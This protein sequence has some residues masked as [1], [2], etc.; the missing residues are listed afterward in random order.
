LIEVAVTAGLVAALLGLVLAALEPA[1]GL[2]TTQSEV[3]DMQQ[4]LRAAHDAVYDDLVGVGAG[5]S[6]GGV[7]ASV[8]PRSGVAGSWGPLVAALPPVWPMRLGSRDADSPGTARSDRVTLLE[9]PPGAPLAAVDQPVA[10]ADGTIAVRLGPGCAVG[11]PVCGFAQ[12]MD[13]LVHD[14]SGAFDTFTIVSV[15]PP[16]LVVRHTLPDWPKVYPVGSAL[17]QIESRTY[18]AREA[19]GTRPPQLVRYAGGFHP[20]VPV[21]DYIVGL[22]FEYFGESE[23]PRMVKP[24]SDPE[25]PWTTYGPPPPADPATS[26]A[27]PVTNCVFIATGAPLASPRLSSLGPGAGALVPLPLSQLHDGPF[28][29]DDLAPTRYDADLLR[30]R[31]VEVTIRVQ[32]ALD[33]LRGPAGLLF[34]YGGTGQRADRY[35]PDIE[36]RVRVTPRN[37]AL[38]R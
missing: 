6:H 18:Y 31:S 28:C 38:A 29:P 7:V 23:P 1:Q 13:V 25:G 24:L 33:S 22:T 21:V 34:S 20:D 2:F 16:H 9:V 19:R 35:A 14:G 37:L 30:I 8:A 15:A 12:D 11:H 27:L 5:A 4:R 36:A 10:A 3:A 17:F 26:P 32:A